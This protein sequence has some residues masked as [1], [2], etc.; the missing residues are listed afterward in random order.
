MIDI[1]FQRRQIYT[2]KATDGAVHY[3]MMYYGSPKQNVYQFVRFQ[4]HEKPSGGL[5]SLVPI[6][7][8]F[9]KHDIASQKVTGKHT[10]GI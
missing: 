4:R 9:K 7:Y 1:D 3:G 10:K 2:I 5:P 8:T 6:F